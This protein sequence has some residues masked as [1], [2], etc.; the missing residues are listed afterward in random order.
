MKI[1]WLGHA[2]FMLTSNAG[3]RLVTD[4]Y[5]DS[6]GYGPLSVSAEAVCIS[7]HHHDHDCLYAVKGS[8]SV[9][10]SELSETANGFTVRSFPAFHDD[11]GGKKRGANL[12]F[13]IEADGQSVAHL[14][15]LGHYPTGAL[16]KFIAGADLIL[17]PVGGYYTID[18]P[19]AVKILSAARPRAAVPM[20]FKNAYCGFPI[21]DESE[22]VR[23][24]HAVYAQQEELDVAKMS[25]VTVMKIA[26][27]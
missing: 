21:S 13:R 20:H 25:G 5:D 1:K 27:K 14:G 24:T 2:C 6:V 16:L 8:P 3:T 26:G 17:I 4:P 9:Y 19:T 15:D 11:A 23:L 12:V 22:F 7:H 18:T 10:D